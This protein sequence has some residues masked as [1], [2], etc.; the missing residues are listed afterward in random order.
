M[1]GGRVGPAGARWAVRVV[2]PSKAFETE[3]RIGGGKEPVAVQALIPQSTV[4]AFDVRI[5]NRFTWLDERQF[6][7]GISSPGIER[8]TPEF[9]PVVE[10]K[11]SR[12]ATVGDRPLKRRDDGVARETV[13][14]RHGDAFVRAHIGD[15]ER[16]K[17]PPMA[18]RVADEVNAPRVV[19]ASTGGRGTRGTASR[20]RWRVRTAKPSRRYNR[21]TRS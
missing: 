13:R 8:A 12:R 11:T 7:V 9:T 5:L 10:R 20:F 17:A 21:S 3:A 15:G 4:E 14:H 18:Q 1:L 19:G 16:A 6:D 2:I